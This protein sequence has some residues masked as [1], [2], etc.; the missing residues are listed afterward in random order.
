MYRLHHSF[1]HRLK[2]EANP[3][4]PSPSAKGKGIHGFAG[5]AIGTLR[6]KDW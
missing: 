2:D 5:D 3:W 6:F 1:G 4:N